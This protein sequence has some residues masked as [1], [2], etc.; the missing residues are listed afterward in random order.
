MW[1]AEAHTTNFTVSDGP[2]FSL[3]C[4]E[5]LLLLLHTKETFF[6]LNTSKYGLLLSWQPSSAVSAEEYH[7]MLHYSYCRA[8][9]KSVFI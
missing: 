9:F 7:T 1:Q 4:S 6:A 2:V 8:D 5:M 3:M